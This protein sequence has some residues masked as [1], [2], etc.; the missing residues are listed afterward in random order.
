MSVAKRFWEGHLLK[1][2][3]EIGFANGTISIDRGLQTFYQI[4]DYD[5]TARREAQREITGTIEHGF[6]DIATFATGAFGLYAAGPFTFNISASMSDN[7][8]V[9]SGCSIESYDL[10]LPSDGWITETIN[11]RAKSIASF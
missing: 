9:L 1:G 4:G 11:F 2:S 10:E 3:T 8:I 7:A 6:I 5:L